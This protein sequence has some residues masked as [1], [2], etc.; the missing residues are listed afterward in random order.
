MNT[1]NHRIRIKTEVKA[2]VVAAVWG[3]ELIQFLSA[4][5]IFHQED[6]EEK[7]E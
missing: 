7:D 1:S 5:A 3:T 6:F 4:P 2:K